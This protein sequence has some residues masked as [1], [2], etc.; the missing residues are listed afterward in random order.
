[1]ITRE[2]LPIAD[3]GHA[4]T[5][6]SGEQVRWV[7][8]TCGWQS[9]PGS[10][11]TVAT[12]F[13]SHLIG[14]DA[15]QVPPRAAKAWAEIVEQGRRVALAA[16]RSRVDAGRP[17]WESASRADAHIKR[18][19]CCGTQQWDTDQCPTCVQVRCDRHHVPSEIAA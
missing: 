6:I 18:C 3:D 4:G 12:E 7:T 9:H 13:V 5:L 11:D 1:M 15:F 10:R 16:I 19:G 17:A 14:R 8:C 2:A